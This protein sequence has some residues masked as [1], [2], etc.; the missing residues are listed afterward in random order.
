MFGI[1]VLWNKPQLLGVEFLATSA[2]AAVINI[3]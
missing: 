3:P 2:E 1:E